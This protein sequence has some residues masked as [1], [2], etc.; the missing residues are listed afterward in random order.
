MKTKERLLFK[1][2]LAA[3]LAP[4][5]AEQRT[6]NMKPPKFPMKFNVFLRRAFGG[7][8]HS[9]RL[10]MFRKFLVSYLFSQ[11]VDPE[12]IAAKTIGKMNQSGF[13]NPTAYFKL[14]EDIKKWREANRIQQRKEAAKSRWAKEKLKKSL[15]GGQ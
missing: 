4:Y 9:E 10:H 7:R 8:L 11:Y 2:S 3:I 5:Y 13:Y 14:M 1:N 6:K 12:D 15:G